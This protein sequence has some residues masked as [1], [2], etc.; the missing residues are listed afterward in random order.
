[1]VGNCTDKLEQN[2]QAQINIFIGFTRGQESLS[3]WK[4]DQGE[5]VG[6]FLTSNAKCKVNWVAKTHGL[7]LPKEGQKQKGRN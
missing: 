1:M 6:L 7:L 5:M 4:A 2:C 3:R